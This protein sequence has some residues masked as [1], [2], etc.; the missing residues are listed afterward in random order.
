MSFIDT[1]L[2]CGQTPSEHLHGHHC[3]G[4]L[5]I[6][7]DL[8]CLGMLQTT[9]VQVLYHLH[10]FQGLSG[11]SWE[12]RNISS[13]ASYKCLLEHLKRRQWICHCCA[14]GLG[15]YLGK[16]KNVS[17]PERTEFVDFSLALDLLLIHGF[18]VDGDGRRKGEG[19]KGRRG[20]ILLREASSC[21]LARYKWSKERWRV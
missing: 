10:S 2:G 9:L 12:Q 3:S 11:S 18:R 6:K 16:K 4:R 7:E 21:L 14:F 15:N 19:G 17:Q 8:S 20:L 1:F 5:G 13:T